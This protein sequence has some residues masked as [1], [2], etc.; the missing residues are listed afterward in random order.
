MGPTSLHRYALK[1]AIQVAK[2][3]NIDPAIKDQLIQHMSHTAAAASAVAAS[4]YGRLVYRLIAIALG[5][6]AILTIVFSFV[7]LL[8]KH[9]VDSAFYTLGSAA[10]GALGGVF[11]PHGNGGTPPPAQASAVSP[12]G[13]SQAG[14]GDAG[15]AADGPGTP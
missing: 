1:Q 15:V 8:G 4:A 11:A 12:G 10:I 5:L 6:A 2:D 13:N 3:P 7:L 14:P 9:M